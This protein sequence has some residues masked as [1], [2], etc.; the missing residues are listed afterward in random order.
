M[1]FLKFK[2]VT[3]FLILKLGD[4][5]KWILLMPEI[6]ANVS[7]STEVILECVQTKKTLQF[8]N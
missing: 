1:V 5:K 8:I 4:P 7:N 2:K 3:S 6:F